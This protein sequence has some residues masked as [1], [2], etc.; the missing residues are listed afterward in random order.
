MTQQS[1]FWF[2]HLHRPAEHFKLNTTQGE[3]KEERLNL[4]LKQICNSKDA[5]NDKQIDTRSKCAKYTD[6]L[7][8]HLSG[9]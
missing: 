1:L 7:I 8:E 6:R 4:N 9:E 2:N 5:F 3:T